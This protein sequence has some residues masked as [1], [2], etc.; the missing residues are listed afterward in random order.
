[1]TGEPAQAKI[2]GR[3][4]NVSILERCEQYSTVLWGAL[5]YQVKNEHI[6]ELNKRSRNG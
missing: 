6:R 2:H 5:F 4:R 1:M 3:W